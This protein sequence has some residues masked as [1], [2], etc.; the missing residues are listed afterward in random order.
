MTGV[1]G[2]GSTACPVRGATDLVHITAGRA[3]KKDERR[4]ELNQ[5]RFIDVCWLFLWCPEPES[6]RY[7]LFKPTDFK[8]V[9]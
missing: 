3:Q 1:S 9:A 2:V 7:G 6:N 4:A 5:I 8:S